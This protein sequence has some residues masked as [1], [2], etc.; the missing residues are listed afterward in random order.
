MKSTFAFL[1]VL[2]VALFAM[3]AVSAPQAVPQQQVAVVVYL[4]LAHP[5]PFAV[6][7]AVSLPLAITF[8]LTKGQEWRRQPFGPC[9][10]LSRSRLP[11][12]GPHGCL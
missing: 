6:S 7:F 3:I 9:R 10:R 1:L 8:A 11:Q 4:P 12:G 5:H 2:L